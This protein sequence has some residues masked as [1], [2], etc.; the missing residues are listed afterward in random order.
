M[1]IIANFPW[2]YIG[3]Y[4]DNEIEIVSTIP[5][6]P[7]VRLAVKDSLVESNMGAVTFNLKRPDGRHEEYAYVMGRLTATKDAGAIYLGVRPQGEQNVR[8][9]AYL[10]STVALFSVPVIAPNIG[11]ATRFYTDHGKFCINW[12]DDTGQPT[13]IVYNTNNGSTDESTWVAVGRLRI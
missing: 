7:K 9:V 2:G 13:G 1:G 5:D 12:Q 4:D 11:K 3:T 10:D 8:Q 6:P